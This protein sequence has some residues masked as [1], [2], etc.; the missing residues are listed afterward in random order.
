MKKP[1]LVSGGDPV[2]TAREA[3]E[4][5]V[6]AIHCHVR[7]LALLAPSLRKQ[8]VEATRVSLVELMAEMERKFPGSREHSVFASVELS[9]RRLS[10]ANRDRAKV[11]AMFQGVVALPVLQLMTKWEP[12]EVTSLASELIETGLATPGYHDHISLNPALCPYLR[13]QLDIAQRKSWTTRWIEAMGEYVVVLVESHLNTEMATTVTGL[14]LP[15]LF[16]LLEQVQ[17]AGDAK[18]TIILANVLL[19]LLEF[20]GKP[21][22][23]KRVEQVIDDSVAALDETWSQARFLAQYS[24]INQQVVSGHLD[25]AI[26]GAQVLLQRARE[27]GEQ[28][29]PDADHDLAR[30]CRLLALVLNKVSR[31]ECA[32]PLLE[33]SQLRFEACGVEKMV[34]TC[35]SERGDCLLGLGRF[36]EAVTAYEE[37]IGYFRQQ[38]AERSV[39]VCKG[40]IGSVRRSQGRFSEAL[41][42]HAEAREYF[43][44]LNER[45]M[46][47]E[48]WH[49]TGMVYLDIGQSEAAEDA[50]RKSL[51]LSVELEDIARQAR[52]LAELGI[53]YGD[54]L[55]RLDEAASFYRQAADRFFEI[56]NQ[57]GEGRQRCNLA[58]CLGKLGHLPEARREIHRA[59]ECGTKSGHAS[60]PWS[61]WQT[62]GAIENQAGNLRAS[63]EARARAID[64]YLSYRRDGGE[65]YDPAGRIS[66]AVTHELLTGDPTAAVSLLQHLAANPKLPS[67]AHTYIQ[68][69]Q[70]IVAGSRDIHLADSPDLSLFMVAEII[71]LIETMEKHTSV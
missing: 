40:M 7:T 32:L 6:D 64:A 21:R 36:D 51:A 47:A 1:T 70:A 2:D 63:A 65:D 20:Q 62:L 50:Y 4:E 9:L 57:A 60:E 8:G 42:A 39:A 45:G 16:V 53:L 23:L 69:L 68:A 34:A 3:I 49:E 13:G 35:I 71:L 10:P 54:V 19:N 37:A 30:A 48:S 29:Y 59:I 18:A 12:A 33:E 28:V 17:Q 11:L 31:S 58:T 61:C 52:T 26:D 27:A 24:W 55:G 67:H 56:G 66:L 38:S 43:M 5:L 22:L 25:K 44:R 41:Q 14:E 46:V 15:N